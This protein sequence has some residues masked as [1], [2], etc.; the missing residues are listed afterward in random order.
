MIML[1]EPSPY[2]RLGI[3]DP[4]APGLSRGGRFSAMKAP[5]RVSLDGHP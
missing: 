5:R 1:A 3:S 2:F 4:P